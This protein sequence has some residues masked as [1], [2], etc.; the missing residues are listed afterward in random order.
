MGNT[1]GLPS[2]IPNHT[3]Y[4]ANWLGKLRDDKRE[5][6]RAASAAQR[7]ADFCLGFHPDYRTVP[8]EVQEPEREDKLAA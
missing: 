2:D 6:F 1:L 3:N 7:I 8:D 4:I 5:I